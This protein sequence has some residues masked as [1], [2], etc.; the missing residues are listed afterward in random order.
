MPLYSRR[1]IRQPPGRLSARPDQGAQTCLAGCGR[2]QATAHQ[3]LPHRVVAKAVVVGDIDSRQTVENA[4]QPVE[5]WLKTMSPRSA[6][7]I[8]I[9]YY[10]SISM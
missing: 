5:H 2:A 6:M 7:L 10:M 4:T 8:N 9:V 3:A 1:V